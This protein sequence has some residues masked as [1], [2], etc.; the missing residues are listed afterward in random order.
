MAVRQAYPHAG[1]QI[2]EPIM[3][4]EVQTPLEF[5]GSVVGGIARRRGIIMNS[6]SEIDF[7]TIEAEIPLG[8]M[9]GY[10]TE[11]R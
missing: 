11:L 7:S 6:S 4:V 1:A 2:L 9:F 5:Q 3:R 10:S 8:E